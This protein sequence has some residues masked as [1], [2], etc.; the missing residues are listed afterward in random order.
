MTRVS[1][2]KIRQALLML[3]E[4]LE[5]GFE[6]ERLALFDSEGNPIN[7]SSGANIPPGG[8]TGQLLGKTTDEDYTVGW[9]DPAEGGGGGGGGFSVY[10]VETLPDPEVAGPQMAFVS[11]AAQGKQWLLCNGDDWYKISLGGVY[12]PDNV[13]EFTSNGDTNGLI[14]YLGTL[15]G[16]FVNPVTTTPSKLDLTV[17]PGS[18]SSFPATNITARNGACM[19]TLPV[20]VNTWFTF[21][22]KTRRLVPTHVS[23]KSNSDLGN[24]WPDRVWIKGSNDNSTWDTLLDIA[25]AGFT[26]Q[27]QWK[28]WSID[29]VTTPYRYLRMDK[30]PGT[31]V[32]GN[33]EIILDEIEYYGILSE[34]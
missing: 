15:D 19:V 20:D 23:L 10:T 14:Y 5:S 4:P 31:D 9:L 22:L 26:A 27:G 33:H 3:G 6:P 25:H 8:V 18:H 12:T 7:L 16:S 2:Q 17:Q 21:D 34:E 11:D 30:G 1:S 28:D 24:Y 29:G 13:L 32:Q